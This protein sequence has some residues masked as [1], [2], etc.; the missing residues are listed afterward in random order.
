M[1]IRVASTLLWM[2]ALGA[3]SSQ[4]GDAVKGL[5][6]VVRSG[7]ADAAARVRAFRDGN[8]SK[9]FGGVWLCGCSVRSAAALLAVACRSF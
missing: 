7:D 6:S 8:F 9:C 3:Q 2:A 1:T 5:E 4:Q